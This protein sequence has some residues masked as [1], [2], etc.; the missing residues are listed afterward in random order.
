MRQSGYYWVKHLN[1]WRIGYFDMNR[2]FWVM[3]GSDSPYFD[4]EFLEI[5]ER[6]IVR[7]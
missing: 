2:N 3:M 7:N 5:D 4:Q 6:Q 1:R